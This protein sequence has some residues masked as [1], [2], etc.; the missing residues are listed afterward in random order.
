MYEKI[1]KDAVD[2]SKET[3]KPVVI[4]V[5]HNQN[6]IEFIKYD[7][8]SWYKHGELVPPLNKNILPLKCINMYNYLHNI[9][10][11]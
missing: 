2:K 4:S 9:N 11:E 7:D 10:K 1:I 3:L 5:Q 8:T 6:E